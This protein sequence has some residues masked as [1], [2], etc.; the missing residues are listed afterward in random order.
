MNQKL[1]QTWHL[2][3]I[4]QQ[5]YISQGCTNLECYQQFKS[6]TNREESIFT[7]SWW[8]RVQL[9]LWHH[10]WKLHCLTADTILSNNIWLQ[11]KRCLFV[12]PSNAREDGLTRNSN[13]KNTSRLR[14][15][16]PTS[17]FISLLFGRNT[18]FTSSPQYIHPNLIERPIAVRH[19]KQDTPRH[20]WESLA[21]VFGRA[22]VGSFRKG[23]VFSVRVVDFPN[24]SKTFGQK[25]KEK[26]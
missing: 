5:D 6:K 17:K 20:C 25:K 21:N 11:S 9:E 13:A 2:E 23:V 7:C 22:H 3:G 8:K 24:N 14:W 12:R 18:Q 10:L 1:H 26:T 15:F 19:E 4:S 16:Y